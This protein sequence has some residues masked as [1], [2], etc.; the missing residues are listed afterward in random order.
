MAIDRTGI[1]AAAALVALLAVCS[2]YHVELVD[3]L[4]PK[5]AA[6]DTDV[7]ADSDADT[8]TDVDTDGDTGSD[9]GECATATVDLLHDKS[10]IL[11]VLDRS[12]SMY[13][14]TIGPQ[15][16]AEVVADAIRTVAEELIEEGLVDF[17]L[18]AFPSL[19]CP[20]AVDESEFE[21]A[22]AD[23]AVVEPGPDNFLEIDLA[24][25]ALGTC[26]GTPMC[27][28]L[29]WAHDYLTGDDLP[30]EAQDRPRHVLLA[31]DGAPNCNSAADVESCT[32]TAD[33][34]QLPEQCLDDLCTYNAALLLAADDIPVWVVGVGDAAAEWEDVL[35]NIALYGGTSASYAA[36][37][38]AAVQAALEEIT[39]AA[40]GCAFE[41]PWDAVPGDVDKGCDK[42][43]FEAWSTSW[44]E[45]PHV[46]DCDG[47][48]GWRFEGEPPAFD[49]DVDYEQYCT[50][51]ELCDGSCA[52]FLDGDYSGVRA[53][54]GCPVAAD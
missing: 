53:R 18:G 22:P 21:C 26:G 15:T 37:D 43:A 34:C 38:E 25:D 54:V 51:I 16:Y 2:C 35:D 48:Q 14:N 50:R 44:E 8:D 20:P 4:G 17:G 39:G 29:E 42:L 7:D 41:V 52:A 46:P 47:A 9:T 6:A 5:D 13:T 45:L 28:S 3:D 23:I 40:L 33:V 49:E 32:C 27:E 1:A 11:I 19:D 10:T 24:L 31:T 30:E 12:R 36:D